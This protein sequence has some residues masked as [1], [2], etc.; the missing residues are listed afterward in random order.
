M[1]ERLCPSC[2]L[3]YGAATTHCPIDGTALIAL[4]ASVHDPLIGRTLSDRFQIL[5][6][7]GSGGMGTVYRA[8]QLS[9]GRD[10]AVKVLGGR[11]ADRPEAVRRFMREANLLA[12]VS[13]PN[14]VAVLDFGQTP[15]GLLFL[16]M[17]LLTGRT[18]AELL[19]EGRGIEVDAALSLLIELTRGIEAA[20]SRGIVHR[21]L[22]PANVMVLDDPPGFPKILDFGIARTLI[23]ATQMTDTGK[24]VGTPHYVA[25]EVIEGEVP[26]KESDIYA[27]GVIGYELLAG[28]RPFERPTPAG[29]LA[30]QVSSEPAPIQR[31][32]PSGVEA[33][34]FKA[35]AKDPTA[36]PAS[37]ATFREL[38]L[39]ARGLGSS[40][41]LEPPGKTQ[42]SRAPWLTLLAAG[43]G[44]VALLGILSRP[45]TKRPPSESAPPEPTAAATPASIDVELISTPPANV[46]VGSQLLGTTPLVYTRPASAA[47]Q[48]IVFEQDGYA[49]LARE[50][51][52][53]ASQRV[54]V[55]LVPLPKPPPPSPSPTRTAP[56]RSSEAQRLPF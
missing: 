53:R 9:L 1:S 2:G 25:P 15:D 31:S 19:D 46:R 52:L 43:I 42:R 10:V 32:I 24:L 56:R 20:H 12:R 16:V 11:W 45:N 18:L 17:E 7:I 37:A 48:L 44:T 36:R 21:D 51:D 27:L 40:G 35:M 38:L 47:A 23:D 28:R 33:V 13:H 55:Q 54:E 26:G 4:D 8:R 50:I 29:V 22:K 41:A 49:S 39:T 34:I 30:A 6:R 3:P 14:V 5:S